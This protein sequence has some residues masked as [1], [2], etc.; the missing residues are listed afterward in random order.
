[1]HLHILYQYSMSSLTSL[2][3][4]KEPYLICSLTTLGHVTELCFFHVVVY[5]T[6]RSESGD[7]VTPDRHSNC[8][9][10][11]SNSTIDQFFNKV[12]W[13]RAKFRLTDQFG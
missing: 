13:T 10:Y 11:Y 9:C 6:V 1:M 7:P 3:G 12:A 4:F 8:D 5:G 2:L